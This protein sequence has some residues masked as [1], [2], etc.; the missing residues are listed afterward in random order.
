MIIDMSH[1]PA[2]EHAMEVG[3]I[4]GIIRSTCAMQLM[5]TV[6]SY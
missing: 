5:D 1:A 6:P 3:V 4:Q 2:L